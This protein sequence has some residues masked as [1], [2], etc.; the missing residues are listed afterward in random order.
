MKDI[1]TRVSCNFVQMKTIGWLLPGVLTSYALFALHVSS[2]SGKAFSGFESG[3][4][5]PL[6]TSA[7]FAPR[8]PSHA[9]TGFTESLSQYHE[10]W[11]VIT[12]GHGGMDH[13]VLPI[14]GA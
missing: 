14:N 5:V 12:L 11:R 7:A 4:V 9:S 10:V 6:L 8:R 3:T 1:V 13:Q 2:H